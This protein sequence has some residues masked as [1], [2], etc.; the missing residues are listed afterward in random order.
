[1]DGPNSDL[2][3]PMS[4][5][6]II[7]TTFDEFGKASGGSKK[8]GSWYRRSP[9]TIFVLNLQKSQYAVRYYVNVALWLLAAVLLTLRS[10]L[11]AT[12][13]HGWRGWCRRLRNA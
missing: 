13:R 9:E 1:M 4:V 3:P 7:Q 10:P 11:I 8:S 12:S 6:N 2:R 5:R